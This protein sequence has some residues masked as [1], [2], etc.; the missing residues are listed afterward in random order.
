MHEVDSPEGE[1]SVRASFLAVDDGPYIAE[2]FR[3]RACQWSD[4]DHC[5]LAMLNAGQGFGFPKHSARRPGVRKAAISEREGE[6]L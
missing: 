5:T 1:G 3:R 4:C 6:P 2:L